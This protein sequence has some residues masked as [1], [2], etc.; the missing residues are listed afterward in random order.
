MFDLSGELTG[1]YVRGELDDGGNLPRIP[2]LSFTAGV[3]A[4]TARHDL[5]LEAEWADVQDETAIE[6]LKTQSYVLVN[7]RWT[8]EPFDDRGMRI[9]LE[10]RNLTDQE[11]R[12]H[13][14]V[15]KDMVPLPGR[16]FRAALV[17][18]F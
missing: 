16:N 7:A 8:M 5:H 1:E 2:P 11:A 12:V 13:T 6:E 10:G 15:L 4:S 9:V 18:D 17:L 14:S 3:T